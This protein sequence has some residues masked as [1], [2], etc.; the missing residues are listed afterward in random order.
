MGSHLVVEQEEGD[1]VGK[2]CKELILKAV[3][4]KEVGDVAAIGVTA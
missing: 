3:G 1:G 4:D 2:V